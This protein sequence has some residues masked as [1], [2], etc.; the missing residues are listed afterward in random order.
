MS[1]IKENSYKILRNIVILKIRRDIILTDLAKELKINRRHPDLYNALKVLKKN[2]I[3][4]SIPTFGTAKLL[5][6]DNNKLESFVRENSQEF[7]LW[8]RFIEVTTMGYHY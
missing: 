4:E 5:R 2:H 6:I 8:G 3:I 7:K 1:D